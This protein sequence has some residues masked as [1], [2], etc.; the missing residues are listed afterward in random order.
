MKKPANCY[1][2]VYIN[3]SGDLSKKIYI[4]TKRRS[5]ATREMEMLMAP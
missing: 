3:K 4:S 5:S 2:L 1:E